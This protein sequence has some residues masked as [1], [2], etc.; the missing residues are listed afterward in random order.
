MF[1][2][3]KKAIISSFNSIYY[4]ELIWYET[5]LTYEDNFQSDVKGGGKKSCSGNA[6]LWRA[7]QYPEY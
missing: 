1:H 5:N 3:Q 6:P 7:V 4:V 2:I